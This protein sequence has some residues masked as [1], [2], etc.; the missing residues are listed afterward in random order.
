MAVPPHRRKLLSIRSHPVKV[1]LDIDNP[2]QVQYLLPFLAA[3]AAVGARTVITARDYESTVALL[4]RAGVEASVF[5][6]RVGRGKLRK[7][8]AMLARTRDLVRFFQEDGRP[9]VLLSASR[10]SAVAA[11][12]MG[13]PSFIIGDYEYSNLTIYRLA[14]STI[15]HPDAIGPETFRRRG[16]RAAQLFSFRGFKEDITFARVDI[17][18]VEPHPLDVPESFVRVLFRPPSETSHYYRAESTAMARAALEYLAAAG[19]AV[20]FSPRER[21]QVAYLEGLDWAHP[22]VVLLKPVPF[23]ALL[24]SVDAVVCSGGTMLREAAYLGVPAYSIFKSRIGGVDRRLE[25]LRRATLLHS[26]A[27]LRRL[28]LEKRG[29]LAP[30]DS[31]PHLVEELVQLISERVAL[32]ARAPARWSP[33]RGAKPGLGA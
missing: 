4:E 16:M 17:D 1:W 26:P 13:I 11:R 12:W 25:E 22:P 27:D 21:R 8:G 10:P 2:P 29:E 18:E 6:T 19:V 32:Q 5:G 20:V 23:L 9:D 14:G 30:L 15:L 33:R 7:V 3:F 31:N 28:K 24:K